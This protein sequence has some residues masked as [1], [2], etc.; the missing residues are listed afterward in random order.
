MHALTDRLYI[1]PQITSRD[2]LAA[3]AAQGV[4][5]LVCHR[6]DNEEPG[7]PAFADIAAWAAEAGI[8]HCIHQPM[9]AD[10]LNAANA[11][12]FAAVVAA[13]DTPVLAYCRTGTRC[14]VLWA[15]DAVAHGLSPQAA[16]GQAA[17]VGIDLQPHAARLDTVRPR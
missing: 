1:S 15:L 17:A 8:P 10:T 11:A 3:A 9:T 14:T 13:A 6:P 12:E 5:T 7:Q 16:T 2:T 4:R